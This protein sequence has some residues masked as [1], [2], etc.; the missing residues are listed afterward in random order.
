MHT[1][2]PPFIVS[3][4]EEN[5][6]NYF[7]SHE[8]ERLITLEKAIGTFWYKEFLHR[9]YMKECYVAGSSNHYELTPKAKRELLEVENDE[10]NYGHNVEYKSEEL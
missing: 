10:F 1:E 2:K 6:L 7:I 3:I 4:S 5:A 8:N 9:G